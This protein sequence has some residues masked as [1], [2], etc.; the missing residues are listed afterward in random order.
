MTTILV[1]VLILFLFGIAFS[2]ASETALFSLSSIKINTYGR[3]ADPKKRLIAHLVSRPQD[4]LITMI[5]I[6]VTMSILIQNLMSTLFGDFSGWALTV[7]LPLALILIF[8]E[9]IPKSIGFANNTG[10]SY[11]VA[12]PLYLIQKLLLPFRK[13]LLFITNKIFRWMFF[14]LKK[15]EEISVAELEH[16]LR[17]S[18]K[19]GVL[20]AD[21]ADLMKGYLNLEESTVK[22]FMRPREEV[23]FFDLGEPL[24]DI[25]HLFVDQECTRVPVCEGGLDKI[26]GIMSSGSFF[27]NRDH[28]KTS[29]DLVR[30]LKKPF[31]IPES[32]SA[33]TL[34]DKMYEKRESLAIAVDEYGS[35]SGLISLEDLV[36]AVVGEIADRRDEKSR[37]TRAG[38]NVIIASGK[39]ELLELE[40]IFDVSLPS[41]NQMVTVG[42][43]LTEQ[44]GD[45][46]K[47]GTKYIW[48]NLLFHVLS[49]DK[50]RVKRVYIR[51]LK[52]QEVKS[53]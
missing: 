47:S 38:E 26:K 46:P 41:E 6:N 18:E 49:S 32:S 16:A 28:I 52:P 8:G 37:F 7:A 27:I 31:F 22:E 51:K 39:L 14:Y 48:K 4:L 17:T 36:E 19:T 45:I 29:A 35:F 1:A 44:L 30:F 53:T 50:K 21:E 42:G 24:S 12:K 43:W 33:K 10:I 2:A 11:R 5:I 20:A 15:E 34:L 23:L 25:L 3:D 40:A 13:V 9:V